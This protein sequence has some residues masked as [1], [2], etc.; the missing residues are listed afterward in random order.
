MLVNGGEL[1]GARILKPETAA[2]QET[3]LAGGPGWDG[4]GNTFVSIDPKNTEV[5][6]Y[7]TQV[8]APQGLPIQPKQ[9][10]YRALYSNGKASALCNWP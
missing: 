4:S 10:V 7:M 8:I 9:I 1:D 3:M 6:V 5:V 2:A